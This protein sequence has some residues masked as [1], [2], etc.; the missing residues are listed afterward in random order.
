[1]V[2]LDFLECIIGLGANLFYNSPMEACIVICRTSKPRERRGQV[3]F[4]NAVNEVTRKNA[5]SFLEEQHIRKIADAYENFASDDCFSRAVTIQEIQENNFSLSIP[6]YVKEPTVSS[7][8][9]DERTLQEVFQA[10]LEASSQMHRCYE[11]LNAMIQ[12]G[13]QDNE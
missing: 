10:W 3:L 12:K 6:L 11:E 7:E 2:K 9:T 4:I 13:G 5:Q 8:Q 1:L